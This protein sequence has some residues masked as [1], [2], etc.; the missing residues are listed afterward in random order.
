MT[1][2]LKLSRI[3]LAVA[4]S[5]SLWAAMSWA[6][7]GPENH[8][9]HAGVSDVSLIDSGVMVVSGDPRYARTEIFE[10]L[11]R[12]DGGWVLVNTITAA[13]GRYRVTARFDFDREWNAQSAKGRGLYDDA[14]VDITLRV[15]GK[16]AR[17]QVNGPGVDLEPVA[18]CDPNCFLNMSPSALAMFV[19]TR[20][21][22]RDRKEPQTFRWAGQDLDRKRTLSGGTATLSYAGRRSLEHAGAPLK[23]D[24]YT[25]VERLPTPTG[26]TFALDFDLW[27]DSDQWPLGFRVRTPGGDPS[28]TVGFRQGYEALLPALTD[29]N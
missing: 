29:S 10:Y 24:H 15:A 5:L 23:V 27:T 6:A 9:V 22:D 1:E 14:P 25:F 4:A 3:G 18:T 17:I 11:R 20:H 12:D 19:M 21:Y 13:D 8:P 2:L 28:G 16:E 7:P 26:G